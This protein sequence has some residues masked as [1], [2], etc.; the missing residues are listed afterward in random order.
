MQNQKISKKEEAR[1]TKLDTLV[2][3]LKSLDNTKFDTLLEELKVI[4]DTSVL[5]V[6][7][8][9]YPQCTVEQQHKLIDFMADI[10]EEDA[11]DALIDIILELKDEPTRVAFLSA[12]WNNSMDFSEYLL[13]FAK[14][15]VS[16]S[17][18]EAI[19]CHT[20]IDNL[21]GPFEEYVVL[22]AKMLV[23]DKLQTVK[24]DVQKVLI[25]SDILLKIEEFDQ[26]IES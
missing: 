14:I 21:E 6:F 16:G 12:V 4:G 19:E 18:L 5:A 7:A 26:N 24:D 2:T 1:K 23:T 3:A 11:Q 13:E 20:I 22:D 8:E 10:R 25:L 15:A 17:F 9:I